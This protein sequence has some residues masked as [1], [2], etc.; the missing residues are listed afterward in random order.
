M[1]IDGKKDGY[2]FG[3]FETDFG[4]KSAGELRGFKT[5]IWEGGHRVPFIAKW[6]DKIAAGTVSDNLI[7]LT[8]MMASFAAIIGYDISDDMGEDSFNALPVILGNDHEI[9]E[10]IIHQDYGGNLS[11]RQGNFK[12]VGDKLYNISNDIT[13][14]TDIADQYPE[15]V[16]ELKETLW[17][18]VE[19]NR[20]RPYN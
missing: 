18:Q 16:L 2:Y 8:D 17:K 1:G 20:T 6:P 4:H 13:E 7:C 5:S 10:N 12:L 3:E 15:K 11:I 14:R 9:R 19:D